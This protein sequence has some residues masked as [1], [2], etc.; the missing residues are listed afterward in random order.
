A[1]SAGGPGDATIHDI[2]FDNN[3]GI[4]STGGFSQTA[5]FGSY[6][7]ASL[8]STNGFVA[9][10]NPNGIIRPAHSFD[11]SNVCL[12]DSITIQLTGTVS[13]V[14]WE[15]S[16]DNGATWQPLPGANVDSIRVCPTTHTLYRS[17]FSNTCSSGMD[18]TR[19]RIGGLNLANF[20]G[21]PDSSCVSGAVL[22]FN[23]GPIQ[24]LGTVSF[25]SP[26]FLDLGNGNMKFDPAQAG[27]GVH[28]VSYAF[29]DSLGCSSIAF[30]TIVVHAPLALSF[31]GLLPNYCGN[32]TMARL[33]TGNLAP[34]GTFA[35]G[36]SCLVDLG[37]GTAEFHPDLAPLGIPVWVSY[38]YNN[39][40]QSQ[41][42]GGTLVDSVPDAEIL[43]FA[44]TLCSD[45]VLLTV[46]ANS[47]TGSFSPTGPGLTDNGNGTAILDPRQF[48]PG[49]HF[50]VY[51]DTSGFCGD[52][53]TA[54]F[55]VQGSP[56]L[57]MS[58][59]DSAYCANAPLDTLA[60]N[61][62][63]GYIFT[64]NQ[65]FLQDIGNGV[66][67]FD[68]SQAL[69]GTPITVTYSHQTS[70]GCGAMLSANTIVHG[71]PNPVISN[72][73]PSY[74][75]TDPIATISGNFG[76]NGNFSSGNWLTPQGNSLATV[77]PAMAAGNDTV[78]VI[79][80][81]VDNNGCAAS[82]SQWTYVSGLPNAQA[83]LD[84]RICD[85]DSATL[86]SPAVTGESYQWSSP[87]SSW[88]STLAQPTI[89]PTDSG[90]YLVIV[91]NA[92]GCIAQD[93]VNVWVTPFASASAGN[94][95]T[96]CRGDSVTLGGTVATGYVIA[97]SSAS[98]TFSNDPYP[99]VAPS[100]TQQ[101]WLTL[102]DAL[103]QCAD[104]DLVVV[105]V[106]LPATPADAG[107]DQILDAASI[108]NLA[109][110]DPFPG[111]GTWICLNGNLPISNPNAANAVIDITQAGT[112]TLVWQVEN[113]PCPSSKDSMTIV[114]SE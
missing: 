112:W 105:N 15:S 97:W 60:G 70:A 7:V 93:T 21:L 89:V 1:I 14:A 58:G 64:P 109:G 78:W 57:Q 20:T 82:D 107:P 42:I 40:C 71:L 99:R 51:A 38:S 104:S 79:Y 56:V 46:Y 28:D 35:A 72:L 54:T 102:S 77:N 91:S 50:I 100:Q 33:I 22:F 48:A 53:D 114:V 3:C 88:F 96:I 32:D 37:N 41:Y 113:A 110:S 36:C 43:G 29:T 2:A 24:P 11:S 8:S 4:E 108:L 61:F 23:Y 73:M 92:Y 90:S 27:V 31:S 12:G 30:D 67:V 68:P 9:Q 103:G 26:G 6:A 52:A 84:Q 59:L 101:Y 69:I 10:V 83:G 65:S 17:I 25:V 18:T 76:G 74:C 16:T 95:A 55:V 94:D 5:N 45:G 85:G 106:I 62:A 44:D 98:G 87:G 63:F 39:G 34:L 49:S 13:T 81:V 75:Q 47:T 66:A 19:I 111:V 86:G 80:G